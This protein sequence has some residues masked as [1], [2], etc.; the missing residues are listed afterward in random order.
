MRLP[1]KSRHQGRKFLS[2]K[3]ELL[4]CQTPLLASKAGEKVAEWRLIE[5]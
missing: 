1:T 3:T 2:L 5:V 4:T